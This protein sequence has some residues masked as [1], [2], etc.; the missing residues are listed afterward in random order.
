MKNIIG[1]AIFS[2]LSAATLPANAESNSNNAVSAING[3]LSLA[4]GTKQGDG[5]ITVGGILDIPVME[6]YGLQLDTLYS[7]SGSRNAGGF[8]AHYFYRDPKSFLAGATA[9]W[10]DV[11]GTDIFRVGAE[12]EFYIDDFTIA[13]SFGV[14][15]G[16]AYDNNTGYGN[17]NL[18]YY[19]EDNIKLSL[20]GNRYSNKDGAAI[21]AE[22][23]P[24]ETTPLSV[25]LTAGDSE[26]SKGFALF[27]LRYSFG[28][29]GQSLKHRHRYSDPENLLESMDNL[30]GD[31]I[32]RDA[33]AAERAPGFGG[34]S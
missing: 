1:I 23:Q 9:A 31:S 34:G 6:N 5:N 10:Y 17:L 13:P 4:G 26:E 27:G 7:D 28:T 11:D 24:D 16:S 21:K 29:E 19:P 22:W 8:G 3:E 25:Y 33:I 30:F 2:V 15:N 32:S 20:S 14:Q 18:S 12:A